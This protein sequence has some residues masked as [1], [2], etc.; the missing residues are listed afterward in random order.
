[1]NEIVKATEHK[2]T[3]TPCDKFKAQVYHLGE[4]TGRG[5][6]M[7]AELK[8]GEQELIDLLDFIFTQHSGS[9]F[10]PDNTEKKD[11]IV[12]FLEGRPFASSERGVAR[13]G[14]PPGNTPSNSARAHVCASCLSA[15]Y[16]SSRG[17]A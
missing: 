3:R 11:E 8:G 16:A 9:A 2:T 4:Y 13:C 1:M 6:E 12:Q 17:T 5:I 7:L 15:A 14:T 10:N